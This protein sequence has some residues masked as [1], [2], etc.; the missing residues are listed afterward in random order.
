MQ[1]ENKKRRC[2]E[3]NKLISQYNK[4]NYCF[5]HQFLETQ[6]EDEKVLKRIKDQSEYYRR[7][8]GERPAEATSNY[9][10]R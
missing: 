2:L 6:K 10:E 5:N 1:R 7:K 3:C 8:K 4:S 9:K